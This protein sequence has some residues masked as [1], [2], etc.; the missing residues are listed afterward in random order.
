MLN[1]DGYILSQYLQDY[2]ERERLNFLEERLCLSQDDN[3]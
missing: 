3:N 2:I 1:N